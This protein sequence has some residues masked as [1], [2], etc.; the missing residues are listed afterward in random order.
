M[1]AEFWDGHLP[2]KEVLL[3][4]GQPKQGLL[5][6]GDDYF[7]VPFSI[8]WLGY[9][10]LTLFRGDA[11]DS[12]TFVLV[13]TLFVGIGLYLVFGRYILDAWLRRNLHYAVTDTHILIARPAPFARFIELHLEHLPIIELSERG[14]GRGDIRFGPP[15][16]PWDRPSARGGPLS[17]DPAPKFL[18]I[19]DARRVFE[20]IKE[21]AAARKSSG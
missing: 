15:E 10:L 7:L 9:A 5:F 12:A 21:T 6:S 19:E 13:G 8:V 18:A 4:T 20:L 17:L 11:E 16:S 2:H 3:W 14:G 1:K